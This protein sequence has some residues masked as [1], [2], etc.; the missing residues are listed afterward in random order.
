MAAYQQSS[1]IK[2]FFLSEMIFHIYEKLNEDEFYEL[3]KT[4]R[5]LQVD[6]QSLE[7]LNKSLIRVSNISCLFSQT[8]IF[9]SY[10]DNDYDD[11]E[12]I[13]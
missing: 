3:P 2:T 11:T 5:K 12:Q 6:R 8:T 7:E 4:V 10:L 13:S 1:K 9:L